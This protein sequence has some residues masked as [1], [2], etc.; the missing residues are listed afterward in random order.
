MYASSD[1]LAH[2]QRAL[3]LALVAGVPELTRNSTYKNG[4]TARNVNKEKTAFR[5]LKKKFTPM[6]AR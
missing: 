5:I 3:L 4:T 2:C 1:E 6:L